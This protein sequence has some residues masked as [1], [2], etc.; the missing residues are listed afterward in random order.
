[1]KKHTI[2]CLP[3]L[4]LSII[5]LGCKKDE[6]ITPSKN[7]LIIGAWDMG[8]GGFAYFDTNGKKIKDTTFVVKGY[9]CTFSKDSSFIFLGGDDPVIGKY[10]IKGDSIYF[11]KKGGKIK[12]L[13]KTNFSVVFTEYDDTDFASDGRI[14]ETQNY[15][16]GK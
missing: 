7:E 16:K 5:F 1:M 3:L 8:S 14:E 4:L 11:N 2:F 15:K 6:E 12:Q 13:D 10:R 9:S